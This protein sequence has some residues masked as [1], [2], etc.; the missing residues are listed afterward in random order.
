MYFLEEA[1]LLQMGGP[2]TLFRGS[3]CASP[4]AKLYLLAV[5]ELQNERDGHAEK[6]AP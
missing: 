1:F 4:G 3:G 6:C 5:K 2:A